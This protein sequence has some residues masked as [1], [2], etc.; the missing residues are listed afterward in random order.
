M[1]KYLDENYCTKQN[2]PN[3]TPEALQNKIKL[4]SPNRICYKFFSM[5]ESYKTLFPQDNFLMSLN[6]KQSKLDNKI[7]V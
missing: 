7:K 1:V 4:K 2:K 6:L 3:K 5:V